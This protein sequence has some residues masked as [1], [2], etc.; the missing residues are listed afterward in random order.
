VIKIHHI[1]GR[2]SER[3]AWALEELG[4]P[5]EL[6]FREGDVQGS[7]ADLS[8]AHPMHMAPI[9]EDGDL[10]LIESGAILDYIIRTYGPGGLAPPLSS[11]DYQTYSTFMHFAEGSAMPRISPLLMALMRGKPMPEGRGA[12]Q[13]KDTLAFLESEL[14]ARPYFAGEQFSAADIMMEF[15]LKLIPRIGEGLKEYPRLQAYLERLY[16]RPAYKRMIAKALPSGRV[17]AT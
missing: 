16:E 5:Y 1:E 6:V 8:K 15:P 17:P 10:R 2:R 4:Q 3:I 12:Q 11:P 9:V 7:F 14:A 13:L